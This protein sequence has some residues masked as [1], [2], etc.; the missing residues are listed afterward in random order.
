MLVDRHGLGQT[1]HHQPAKTVFS[2]VL[3]NTDWQWTVELFSGWQGVPLSTVSWSCKKQLKIG[4]CQPVV[5]HLTFSSVGRMI[6]CRRLNILFRVNTK[7]KWQIQRNMAKTC[8]SW[9]WRQYNPWL[10]L[11][12]LLDS[13][14]CQLD[15]RGTDDYRSS[16]PAHAILD[17]IWCWQHTI[18][19][20]VQVKCKGTIVR[21]T[22]LDSISCW[23]DLL[24]TDDYI[25]FITSSCNVCAI[26]RCISH[27]PL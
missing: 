27:F 10:R 12:A 25:V 14:S 23:L 3:S 8:M 20:S 21:L 7:D 13:I 17:N 15:L 4:L 11:L 19:E 1:P 26:L 6:T 24:G 5:W 16:S 22:P 2:T 18:E 9:W